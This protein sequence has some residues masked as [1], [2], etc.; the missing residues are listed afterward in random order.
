MAEL[1]ERIEVAS[2]LDYLLLHVSSEIFVKL[3]QPDS[4]R[5]CKLKPN[6]FYILLVISF[7]T[8]HFSFNIFCLYSL[9]YLLCH[10]YIETTCNYFPAMSVERLLD[11]RS[12]VVLG[13]SYSFCLEGS[14]I[15]QAHLTRMDAWETMHAKSAMMHCIVVLSRSIT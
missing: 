15:L 6:T 1:D 11:A 4:Q 2:L 14:L 10:V 3:E 12:M 7:G 8:Q 5:M 13:C 9:F